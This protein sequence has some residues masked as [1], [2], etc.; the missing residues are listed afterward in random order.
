[1]GR[2]LQ[3]RLRAAS[4]VT[5]YDFGGAVELFLEPGGHVAE[6]WQLAPAGAQR[7]R[8]GQSV[9]LALGAH[10]IFHGLKR[11][12]LVSWKTACR[13]FVTYEAPGFVVVQHDLRLQVAPFAVARVHELARFL[14]AVLHV[15]GAT[16]PLPIARRRDPC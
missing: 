10:E 12:T 7:A 13:S 9:A 6:E 2:L 1:M 15:V 4:A 3:I 5:G 11:E 8:A 16:A 14:V